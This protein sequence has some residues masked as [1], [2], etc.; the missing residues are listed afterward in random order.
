VNLKLEN[1]YLLTYSIFYRT[2]VMGDRS[3]HYGNNNF[4]PFWLLWPWPG[5]DDLHR[6]IRT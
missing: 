5:L 4:R 2:G 6:P 1:T 3:L